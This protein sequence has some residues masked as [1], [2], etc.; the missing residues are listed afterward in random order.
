MNAKKF[1]AIFFLGWHFLLH[2]PKKIF[3]HNGG[4]KK[5]LDDYRPDHIF[6]VPPLHRQPMPHYSLCISCRL[7]DTVC[8]EIITH[9][10]L[11]APSFLVTGYSRSLT[12]H[13]HFVPQSYQCGNCRACEVICPQ[14]VPI[15]AIIDFMSGNA[16]FLRQ[17]T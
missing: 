4:Q 8:P 15:K 7:C 16:N 5:F 1:K 12:D 9:P 2:F 3:F 13:I 14:H 17:Q 6:P 10:E 11:S